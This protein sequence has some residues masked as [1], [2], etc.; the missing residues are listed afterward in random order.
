VSVV[1]V[2]LNHRS[3][4]LDVLEAVAVG[5][6]ALPK[7]LHDLSGRPN[8]SEVVVVSTCMRTEV[9]A[10]VG[11]FH[12]ALGDIRMF[13]AEWSGL[14]PEALSDF[15]YDYY[16]EGAVRH[17][18]RVASGLDSAVLGEGEILRQVRTAFEAARSEGT[19]G[20]TLGLLGRHALETGKRVRTETAIA[21][22]T[23]SLS[24]TALS[25]AGSVGASLDAV[26]PEASR[27]PVIGHGHA[28]AAASAASAAP[29][30]QAEPP[31]TGSETS[32]APCSW[33]SLLSERSVLVI[34]AGE[35]GTAVATLA[36]G[37][38][39]IGAIRVANRT[40]ARA[41]ELGEGIG[42][43]VVG[44]D[45]VPVALAQS[46]IAIVSTAAQELVLDA[47]TV[48][49]ALEAR[50][51]TRPLVIID[52]SMPRNVAPDVASIPGVVLFDVTHLKAHAEAAM[53]GRRREVPAA[54]VIVT[55]E[56]ERLATAS[57]QRSAAPLVAALRK[58]GEVIRQAE[59]TKA[60]ARLGDLDDRQRRAVEALTKGIVAKLLHEPTVNLKVAAG[61]GDGDLL[62]DALHRLFD[63]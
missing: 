38:P 1:V 27:C 58:R 51:S 56:V 52:L 5:E 48:E 33:S 22:G 31:W 17:V 42:A 3:A 2:G 40:A 26:P 8:L 41:A 57:N 36:A 39:G 24:H 25:L 21:R 32:G 47:D 45:E 11:R 49:S 30:H 44:W 4:P 18:L 61:E 10:T 14:A 53:D 23:T 46:D 9:Y 54:E 15:L 7:A 59:L 43:A 35:M 62:A 55:E 34:G 16:A 20:T 13:L 37:A 63:L 6:P 12:G 19:V 29:A 50:T 60:Q 28:P